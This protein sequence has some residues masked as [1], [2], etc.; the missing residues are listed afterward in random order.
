MPVLYV[1]D[2]AGGKRQSYIRDTDAEWDACRGEGY[3]GGCAAC[4]PKMTGYI[5]PPPGAVAASN[6][7]LARLVAW[8]A[9]IRCRRCMDTGVTVLG[10]ECGCNRG[11]V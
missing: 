11:G 3:C 5:H 6:A 7:A 10:G 1:D 4:E 8:Q 2:G 9:S